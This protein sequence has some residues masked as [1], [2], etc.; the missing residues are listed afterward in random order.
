MNN[1]LPITNYHFYAKQTQ[2]KPISKAKELFGEY[3]S[4][5]LE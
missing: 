2:T 1:H 3:A 5:N 4:L